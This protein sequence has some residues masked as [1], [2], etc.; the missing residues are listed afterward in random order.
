MSLTEELHA[1][2]STFE[3]APF[4]FVGSGMS[5]RYI[6]SETWAGLLSRFATKLDK[7][8]AQYA[9]AANGD[10]PTIATE[11]ANDFHPHWFASDDYEL[12][13]ITHPDPQFVSTPLKI[14][15]SEYVKELMGNLP[16]EGREFNELESLKKSVIQG[17]IT[18]NYDPLLEHLFPELEVYV[19]QEDL[20]F[21]NPEG[22]GELYKIH[23]SYT[24]P[25][26]L[27]LTQKDYENF[28]S[29]NAYLAAKLLTI[30]VEHP[31]VF[32]GYSLSDNNVRE[33]LMSIAKVLT[34]D[35]IGL[36]Q[37]RLI[38]VQW[39]ENATDP[40]IN[41]TVIP[42]DALTLP[43][44][45]I[46]VSEYEDIFLALSTLKERLPL[47]LLRRVKKQVTELVLTSAPKNKTYVMSIDEAFKSDDVDVVIGIG[48]HNKLTMTGQGI[49]GRDR[50]DLLRDII[51]PTLPT[52]VESMKLVVSSVLPK[53]LPARTNTPI[54]KY[55]RL[56]EYLNPDGT[57]ASNG[58]PTRAQLRVTQGMKFFESKHAKEQNQLRA[59]A[60]K[61]TDFS[62]FMQ[63]NYW[64]DVARVLPYMD[65][66][67]IDMEVLHAAL[68]KEIES[69]GHV[70]YTPIAKV[71][72][73][74]DLLLHQKEEEA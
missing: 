66:S 39:N 11:L 6:Q 60:T 49:V 5:R 21:S 9:S 23:G 24:N 74:Y 50:Y 14:E 38:F 54:Y 2:L 25:D 13:R 27:V 8:Y 40:R 29:R 12:T 61:I 20:L 17:I 53:N 43:I 10:F 7:P 16:V 4:L 18:T 63:G 47:S 45:E 35:N 73:I 70:M 52:D 1:H 72:C 3:T 48:V 55:L 69:P 26:S 44:L 64:H 57:L 31:V 19:G 37:N 51:N 65:R 58:V 36:L 62:A 22:V 32:L 34:K 46:T 67:K 30:F 42:M 68:K 15:I 33:I 41:K 59:W 28:G 56:S 71:I